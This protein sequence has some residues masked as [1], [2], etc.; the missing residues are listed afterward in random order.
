MLGQILSLITICFVVFLRIK[1]NSYQTI[2]K[3]V[4]KVFGSVTIGV[5]ICMS[6]ETVCMVVITSI[7]KINASSL[8]DNTSNYSI[9][10]I[11]ALS[12]IIIELCII[13][14]L[15][16]KRNCRLSLIIT[17]IFKNSSLLKITISL[18][19]INSIIIFE[20][21]KLI[22]KNNIF[23]EV[24]LAEQIGII[25]SICL[26]IPVLIIL[27]INS[28]VVIL[29]NKEGQLQKLYQETE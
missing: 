10:I 3:L 22:I 21:I 27:L 24:N 15:Y 8:F 26:I 25:L 18:F 23:Y 28:I 16:V 1:L 5:I 13:A 9:K 4:L 14:I 7:L 11:S 6:V 12:W 19:G 17:T 20:T 29:I 2:I